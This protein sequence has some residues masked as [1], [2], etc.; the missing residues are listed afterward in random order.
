MGSILTF[1]II[2]S[3]LILVHELGH[4]WSAK[5]HG[6]KV[7]EFGFGYPPRLLGGKIGQTVYS[8]NLL[9]FSGFVR[10]LGEDQAA[11]NRSFF[12]QK[13]SLRARVLLP[14]MRM[15]FLLGVVFFGASYTKR[16]IPEPVGYLTVSGVAP[17]SPAECPG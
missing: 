14:G 15:N 10:M 1:L 7:E 5:S 6:I 4:F 9:P 2:L 17:G 8:I 11:G 12:V 3:V 16:V 13:K